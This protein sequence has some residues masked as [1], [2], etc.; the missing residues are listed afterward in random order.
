M[1]RPELVARADAEVF[2]Q[3]P[4]GLLVHR[5]R[6]GLSMRAVERHHPQRRQSLSQ[7]VRRLERGELRD[8]G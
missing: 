7:W 1:Q 8:E 5:Q 3:S 4:P 2:G 6:I